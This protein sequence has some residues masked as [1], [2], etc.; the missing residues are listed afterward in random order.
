MIED[1]NCY[2]NSCEKNIVI[3]TVDLW[4]NAIDENR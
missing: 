1:L 3:E 4:L 2:V